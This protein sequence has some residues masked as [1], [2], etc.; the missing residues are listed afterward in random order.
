MTARH[1]LTNL[2][3]RQGRVQRLSRR[4]LRDD[5]ILIRGIVRFVWMMLVDGL[6]VSPQSILRRSPS[7]YVGSLASDRVTRLGKPYSAFTRL[8][9]NL[10]PHTYLTKIMTRSTHRNV[11][12][13]ATERESRA[14]MAA[15]PTITTEL[16]Y[17][18][19][20]IHPAAWTPPDGTGYRQIRGGSKFAGKR[21][22]SLSLSGST[23]Q[24]LI[25]ISV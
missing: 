21:V 10:V 18:G 16:P 15:L 24:N 11:R 4:K 20:S 19:A 25:L 22:V 12:T 14:Q 9:I 6:T 2:R 23:R 17:A 3:S 1:R 7:P 8:F 13:T 5:S